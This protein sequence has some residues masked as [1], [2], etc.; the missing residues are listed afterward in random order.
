M[1]AGPPP[2]TRNRAGCPFVTRSHAAA[3][4]GVKRGE[5]KTLD[6]EACDSSNSAPRS[7]FRVSCRLSSFMRQPKHKSRTR[8]VGLIG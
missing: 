4:S 1:N 7:T 2:T 8:R 3:S 5:P 6:T